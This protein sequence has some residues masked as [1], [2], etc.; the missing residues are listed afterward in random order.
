VHRWMAAG[1]AAL[2][3]ACD[4]AERRVVVDLGLA[5]GRVCTGVQAHVPVPLAVARG[6][7]SDRSD[8]CVLAVRMTSASVQ[9]V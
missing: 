2:L 6:P 9:A 5:V 7:H 8:V 4:R 1:G 3:I